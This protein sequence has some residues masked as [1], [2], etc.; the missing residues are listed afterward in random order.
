MLGL[1]IVGCA[2]PASDNSGNSNENTSE[3]ASADHEHLWGTSWEY[4]ANNHWHKCLYTTCDEMKDVA[5]HEF[6]EWQDIKP[7]QLSGAAQYAYCNPKIRRC[8]TCSY[9]EVDG[10]NILPELRFTT[11]VATDVS[12]A[13]TAKKDDISRPEV[14]GKLSI[15]N[16][17]DEF[18]A[19]DLV[20][21]MKVRG[22]Q[23]AGWSKKAFRLKLDKKKNLLGLNGGKE[24]KKWVLF[25]DAKDTTL[26]RSALG[27]YLSKA[28]IKDGDNV[29]SSDFTPVT[30]YLNDEYWGFYYLAEQKEVKAG[31]VMLPEVDEDYTGTD[32]GYCF[33]LD[34]YATD[35]RKK[36]A[37]A[38]ATFDFTYSPK[39]IHG[40][41]GSAPLA[42]GD[43]STYTL[44]SDITDSTGGGATTDKNSNQVKFIRKRLESLYTVLYNAAINKTA[45]DIDSSG[46]VVSTSKTV[47]QV[48]EEHFNLGSWAAG[49]I[50]NAFTCP[51]DL[52][53]SSFYMSYD[54]SAKGD[55]KLRFDVPWDFD[56]NFGNRNNFITNA[57]QLY[58]DKTHNM[59]IQLFTKIDFFMNDYVKPRWN[60]IRDEKAFEGMM[61]MMKQHFADNDLEIQRNH[62]KWPQNDAAHQ[63]P[64][65]FDEIRDPYKNPD[66]YKEA[67]KETISWCVKRVNY[68]EKQWGNGRPNMTA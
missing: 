39:I 41:T 62:Y 18:K 14:S 17:S 45:K 25:A 5:P 30:V 29:W 4:D 38:D 60:T 65:N 33:E 31:R 50:I 48:M 3:K 13:T 57:D 27:L 51:P 32:I 44:L 68:L 24:F 6:G 37:E 64:N 66:Q 7:S 43:I 46:N 55:K 1:M 56:S 61:T 53:Y 67:E 10:T 47:R 63:P 8:A 2:Q 42:Q 40:D 11:D 54:N 15:T 34:F 21:G 20:C 58:V 28:V 26:V 35:E 12:F 9:Y 49:M 22:N 23:T 59:W 36:G 19:T 52:G 16:C